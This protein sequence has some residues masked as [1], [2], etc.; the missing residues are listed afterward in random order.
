MNN[1]DG[2]EM[3]KLLA[4]AELTGSNSQLLTSELALKQTQ[5][6]ARPTNPAQDLDPFHTL[7]T[8]PEK[9]LTKLTGEIH[10]SSFQRGFLE[11]VLGI[12][13]VTGNTETKAINVPVVLIQQFDESGRVSAWAAATTDCSLSKWVGIFGE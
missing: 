13:V 10:R 3:V 9:P 6:S 12:L 7:H 4:V 11:H 8:E 2:D 1:H 5:L